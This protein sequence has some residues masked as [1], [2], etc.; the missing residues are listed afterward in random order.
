MALRY[1][2]VTLVSAGL[3]SATTFCQDYAA[4][5]CADPFTGCDAA[6]AAMPAGDSDA[7][8]DATEAGTQACVIKH[9]TLVDAA[10]SVHC[11]HARGEGPCAPTFCQNYAASQCADPF[12]GCDAAFAAMP[13]GDSDASND[14]TEAG[15]QACV[16]KHL[17]LVDGNESV[18]CAHAR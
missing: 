16:I 8:N 4:S 5:Q 18:H 12:T 9:L 7:S 3:A 1:A 15:T 17:T 2:F 11:A 13:A 10:D 6:F 14:A